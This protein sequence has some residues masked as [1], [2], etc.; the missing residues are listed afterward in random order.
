MSQSSFSARPSASATKPR[1]ALIFSLPFFS[2]IKVGALSSDGFLSFGFLPWAAFR[3][4]A[5]LCVFGAARP[6]TRVVNLTSV[7]SST[8][9]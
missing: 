2:S 4:R 9:I 1:Q 5:R 6:L 8:G 3:V 7:D